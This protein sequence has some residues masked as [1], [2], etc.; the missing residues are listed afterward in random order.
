MNKHGLLTNES[1]LTAVAHKLLCTVVSNNLIAQIDNADENEAE[2]YCQWE[3]GPLPT[4]LQTQLSND[5]G[6]NAIWDPGVSDDGCHVARWTIST[7]KDALSARSSVYIEIKQFLSKAGFPNADITLSGHEE[8]G[9]IVVTGVASDAIKACFATLNEK[10]RQLGCRQFAL[11]M[12]EMN[13]AVFSTSPVSLNA[14]KRFWSRLS[15]Q[16]QAT[17]QFPSAGSAK[18]IGQP[19]IGVS[20]IDLCFPK[21]KSP[22]SLSLESDEGVTRTA[23]L[24]PTG[25][26]DRLTVESWGN[27]PLN[28][29]AEIDQVA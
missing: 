18:A 13:H 12:N 28:F 29:N 17:C 19:V 25:E 27:E 16:Y 20:D 3:G 5:Y 14:V 7:S 4:S 10:S 22:T 9:L 1:R 6:L 2:I 11:T 24:T 21:S 26:D 15:G 8:V 23:W